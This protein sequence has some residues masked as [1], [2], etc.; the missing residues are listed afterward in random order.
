M[1]FL[2][3]MLVLVELTSTRP[4]F[5]TPCSSIKAIFVECDGQMWYPMIYACD[6]MC[7]V[8]GSC[9]LLQYDK[10]TDPVEES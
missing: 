2:L 9:N 1:V 7:V 10:R 8:V 4:R 3:K 5:V 6:I